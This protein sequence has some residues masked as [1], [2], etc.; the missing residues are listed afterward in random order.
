MTIDGKTL[1]PWEQIYTFVSNTGRNIHI[2]APRL[3]EHCL[4]MRYKP[5]LAPIDV[6]LAKSFI[7]DNIVHPL[8]VGQILENP[9]LLKEPIILCKTEAYSQPLEPEI[10]QVLLVEGHHRYVAAAMNKRHEIL[11][12][13]LDLHQWQPFTVTGIPDY[14]A[15]GLKA[16]PIIPKPHWRKNDNS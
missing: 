15:T 5:I 7:T 11:A 14:T 10:P 8:R 2:H 1:G 13:L 6:H 9:K 12:W 3:R 16:E 4:R